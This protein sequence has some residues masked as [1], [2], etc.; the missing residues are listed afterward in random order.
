MPAPQVS[1]RV[2]AEAIYYNNLFFAPYR[3]TTPGR[4]GCLAYLRSHSH[5]RSVF[6]AARMPAP[7]CHVE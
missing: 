2:G 4:E 5:S 6:P 1:C 7:R 3:D